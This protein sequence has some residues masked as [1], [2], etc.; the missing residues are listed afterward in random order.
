MG[1]FLSPLRGCA[2]A[3]ALERKI[4]RHV[5]ALYLLAPRLRQAG[6]LTPEVINFE[7]RRGYSFL[8]R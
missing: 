2:G 7:D 3:S 6:Y 5:Y 1:Y 8:S 4:D